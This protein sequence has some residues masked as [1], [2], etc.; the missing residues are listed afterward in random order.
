[1]SNILEYPLTI[2][3]NINRPLCV[4][5]VIASLDGLSKLLP[6]T[7]PFLRAYDKKHGPTGVACYVSSIKQ[8]SLCDE[9]L[10]CF[11]FDSPED[12]RAWM[13]KVKEKTG[14]S[15]IERR[16]PML[17]PILKLALCGGALWGLNAL[18]LFGGTDASRKITLEAG[19]QAIIAEGDVTIGLPPEELKRLF[20]QSQKKKNAY[21]AST[22]VRPSWTGDASCPIDL[23]GAGN[24][25]TRLLE[26]AEVA[27]IP[28]TL[29]EKDDQTLL[30]QELEDAELEIRACDMDQVSKGW[31]AIV[32]A[33]SDRR[34]PIR[35]P[36]GFDRSN[37]G[38]A[39]YR[40]DV[41][42]EYVR[43]AGGDRTYRQITLRAIR[44]SESADSKDD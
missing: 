7:L 17:H 28:T 10:A 27:A 31:F 43:N 38:P 35:F 4:E 25:V 32:P 21:A 14:I 30:T 24:E 23:I 2:R 8:G 19:A 36:N 11:F 44:S 40:A 22:L 37:L 26:A 20:V 13:Q 29:H 3:Y 39:V 1:M 12:A 42:L 41:T 15:E 5:D 9:L 18:G 34:L 16:L 6:G 33:V